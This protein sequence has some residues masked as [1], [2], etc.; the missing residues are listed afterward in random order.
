MDTEASHPDVLVVNVPEGCRV[1]VGRDYRGTID[2]T[3]RRTHAFHF[4]VCD[5]KTHIEVL[6]HVPLSARTN[7]P[8]RPVVAA[9][10]VCKR[11]VAC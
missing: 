1:C 11:P 9:A 5:V 3:T 10:S 2:E 6:R 4:Q 7:P 8:G